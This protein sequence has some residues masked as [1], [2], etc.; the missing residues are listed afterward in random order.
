MYCTNVNFTLILRFLL[1][2]LRNE[3]CLFYQKPELI[4][5]LQ[6]I[7][8]YIPGRPDYDPEFRPVYD[9]ETDGNDANS[10]ITACGSVA[11]TVVLMKYA[12]NVVF[13]FYK[14]QPWW[15]ESERKSR[16]W[17][18]VS[19]TIRDD[20]AFI[21]CTKL[22]NPGG[23]KIGAANP[24]GP[25]HF[26][27]DG[28]GPSL[29]NGSDRV[30]VFSSTSPGAVQNLPFE[31]SETIAGLL[32]SVGQNVTPKKKEVYEITFA[33]GGHHNIMECIIHE[34]I[35]YERMS[36]LWNYYTTKLH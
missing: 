10:F 7:K 36:S 19:K 12:N 31:Q 8:D 22:Q 29:Y 23:I 26:M 4:T 30:P 14:S 21:F 5:C 32:K 33:Q 16:Q 25:G 35:I 6:F 34:H 3:C 27:L 13:G 28:N 2:C 20:S 15:I 1:F 18:N 9:S 11:P 17:Q 24:N